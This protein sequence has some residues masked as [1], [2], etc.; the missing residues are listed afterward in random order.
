MAVEWTE[1]MDAALGSDT[2]RNIGDRFGLT[3]DQVGVRRRSLKI[4]AFKPV[5]QG[6]T[7]EE[8]AVL[9]TNTLVKVSAR[10]GRPTSQIIKRMKELDIPPFMPSP[11]DKGRD[12]SCPT[13]I[14][15]A[16]IAERNKTHHK[17][18]LSE[19]L[20]VS[21][22]VWKGATIISASK[23]LGI[24]YDKARRRLHK[25]ERMLRH[26]AR[27]GRAVHSGESALV[28]EE[29]ARRI[30]MEIEH[31]DKSVWNEPWPVTGVTEK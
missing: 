22:L 16:E 28:I 10:L 30:K 31:D 3:S 6:W 29:I 25:F 4:E 7:P 1:E 18:V 27:L 21:L 5:K 23:E 9:G 20:A 8:D 24:T 2:D 14:K 19:G 11:K 13:N 17:E 12:P 26:P 15:E